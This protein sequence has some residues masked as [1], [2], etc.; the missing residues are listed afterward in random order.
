M[1]TKFMTEKEVADLFRVSQAS[2]V[3][4]ARAGLLKRTMLGGT[5]RYA[6]D[7]IESFIRAG[8]GAIRSMLQ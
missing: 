7:D 1:P 8:N 4:W 3:R 2:V 5:I 6:Q